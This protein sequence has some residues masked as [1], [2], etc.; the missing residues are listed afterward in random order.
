MKLGN[1]NVVKLDNK[2]LIVAHKYNGNKNGPPWPLTDE[3]ISL[4]REYGL[5]ELSF[6]LIHEVAP[7]SNIKFRVLYQK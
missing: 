7:I 1:H 4:F 2:L 3:E 5:K 6:D